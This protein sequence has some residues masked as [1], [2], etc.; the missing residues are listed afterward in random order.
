MESELNHF[1]GRPTSTGIASA[2]GPGKCLLW[3]NA[4]LP[5][6]LH[7]CADAAAQRPGPD[8]AQNLPG[9]IFNSPVVGRLH[10]ALGEYAGGGLDDPLYSTARLHELLASWQ[11]VWGPPAV[12]PT[13]TSSP[14]STKTPSSPFRSGGWACSPPR[15]GPTLMELWA[16]AHHQHVGP[17]CPADKGQKQDG[18]GVATT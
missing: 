11:Q 4:P 15:H 5:G 8:V 6:W 17:S 9:H 14:W 13:H 7:F 2:W 18:R 12:W 16:P 1:R 3:L 10:L